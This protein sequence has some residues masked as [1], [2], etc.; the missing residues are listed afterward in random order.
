MSDN[1]FDRSIYR[2]GGLC[3]NGHDFN[4]LNQSIRYLS[5]GRC[6]DCLSDRKPYIKREDVDVVPEY[7][8][9]TFDSLMFKL[10]SLCLRNH[11]FEGTSKS[12]RYIRTGACKECQKQL[13]RKHYQDNRDEFLRKCS[14]YRTE[15]KEQRIKYNREYYK[16]NKLVR[17]QACAEYR[18]R[19][20]EAIAAC[21]AE[22]YKRNKEKHSE[23]MRAWNEKNRDRIKECKQRYRKTICRSFC[24]AQH[25]RRGLLGKY[26]PSLQLL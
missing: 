8:I 17:L 19:N 14:V 2:L 26:R 23:R 6:I 18:S 22:W 12:L 24:S 1:D 11:E 3:K 13:G 25:G 7:L 15:N 20:K 16:R 10:G 21:K 9:G 4:G 5:N